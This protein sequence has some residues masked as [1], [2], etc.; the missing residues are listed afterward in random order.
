MNTKKNALYVLAF[1]VGVG[2]ATFLLLPGHRLNPEETQAY[3]V[4]CQTY[5]MEGCKSQKVLKNPCRSPFVECRSVKGVSVVAHMELRG[6]GTYAP[7][8]KALLKFRHLISLDAE[9]VFHSKM[10]QWIGKLS[11]HLRW[12]TVNKNRLE[13]PLPE[14]FADLKSLERFEA[15]E[16]CAYPKKLQKNPHDGGRPCRRMFRVK[17][18]GPD[19]TEPNDWSCGGLS[20]V[21]PKRIQTMK[22]LKRFWLDENRFSGPLPGWLAKMESLEELDLFANPFTGGIPKAWLQQ[23]AF[24]KLKEIQMGG[25]QIEL[26]TH[27]L[28]KMLTHLPHLHEMNLRSVKILPSAKAFVKRYKKLGFQSGQHPLLFVKGLR[29]KRWW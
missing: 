29:R 14:T 19:K 27:N 15:F 18:D 12:F 2:V 21:L 1:F 9:S 16:Q 10:P 26:R 7:M 20:G 25:T 8:S 3:Q 22:K 23:G 28:V 4:L 13:G 6:Q 24:P 5:Q 17:W 11:P